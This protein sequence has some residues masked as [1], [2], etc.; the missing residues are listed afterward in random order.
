MNEVD[1]I[2]AD[3]SEIL[4]KLV[5]SNCIIMFLNLFHADK[6]EDFVR[7]NTFVL[8][9]DIVKV[10]DVEGKISIYPN[11]NTANRLKEELNKQD[12][13]FSCVILSGK[14]D[15]LFYVRGTEYGI[16]VKEYHKGLIEEYVDSQRT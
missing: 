8:L 4:L 11:L 2:N 13:D 5:S 1:L 16:R 10:I 14:M 9:T 7:A 3:A 6:V 12:G 15:L